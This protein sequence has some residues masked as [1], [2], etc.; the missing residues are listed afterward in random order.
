MTEHPKLESA[1]ISLDRVG[2]AY[3]QRAGYFRRKRFWALEDV[4]LDIHAGETFGIIGKNGSGKSTLMKILAGIIKP[5]RGEFRPSPGRA[6]LLS[7]RLGFVPYLS[8]R[9]NAYMS[10]MLLGLSRAEVRDCMDEILDFSE[11]GEFFDQPISSYSSG[12]L[13]RLGFAVTLTADP[14]VLL[15]DEIW[16]VGDA[17]FR[18]KSAARMRQRA[19]SDKTVVIVS[20]NTEL[21]KRFC[22]RVVW[23]DKGHA[24][25]IGGPEEIIEQ[26][27]AASA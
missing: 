14:E 6:S 3:W 13:A 17:G 20:H 21:F 16:G 10:G 24:K 23:I 22:D 9:E 18:E 7:L 11:L 26:Y 25:A 27:E 12:M 2:V 4:T 1:E 15:I 8:G 5:D 19:L